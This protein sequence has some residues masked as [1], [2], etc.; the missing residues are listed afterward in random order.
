MSMVICFLHFAYKDTKKFFSVLK[1]GF[2]KCLQTLKETSLFFF[3][4][5]PFVTPVDDWLAILKLDRQPNV[6]G[7]NRMM[8]SPDICHE[9]VFRGER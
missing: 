5:T 1:K 9:D 4:E 8:R 3:L 6:A 2:A 7:I